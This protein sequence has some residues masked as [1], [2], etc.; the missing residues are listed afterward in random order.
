MP[1]QLGLNLPSR[2]A[3]GR[4]AFF[5]APS[6][7]AALHMVESWPDW[8]GGKLVLTGP[9]GSGKTHLVHVWSQ[10]ARAQVFSAE[11]LGDFSIPDVAVNGPVAVEDVPRIAGNAD[12]EAALFHLHNMVLAEGHTILFT[13]TNAVVDWELQ[14]PDLVSRLQGTVSVALEPPDDTLLSAV[15]VKLLADR[16]LTPKSDLVPY[17]LKRMDRSFAAAIDVV[18][19]LDSESIAQKKAVTRR[20]AAAVLDNLN[21]AER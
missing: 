17:L 19:R 12:L 18:D 20:L 7:A 13:G 21:D 5:V 8:S 16:Q 6:N 11:T 2:P 1:R 4:N 10:L 15:L 14:L 3:L 9:N